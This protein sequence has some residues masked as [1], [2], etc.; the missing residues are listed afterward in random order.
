MNVRLGFGT[1]PP[2]LELSEHMLFSKS[3]ERWME[4]FIGS[5]DEQLLVET[6]KA[7]V[8]TIWKLIPLTYLLVY[9]TVFC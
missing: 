8:R 4:E 1:M 6:I 7:M 2:N 5:R 9:I 3:K